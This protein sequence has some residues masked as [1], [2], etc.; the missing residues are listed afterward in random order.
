MEAGE[1]VVDGGDA[2]CGPAFAEAMAESEV[3]EIEFLCGGGGC[4]EV[5]AKVRGGVAPEVFEG[6]FS[7]GE[8]LGVVGEEGE[9]AAGVEEDADEFG[10]VDGVDL[11]VA[12][13]D[14]QKDSRG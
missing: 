9:G 6:G 7:V 11:L 12:G 4:A 10:E 14:A 5:V 1:G 3:E 8:E 13:V 2:V